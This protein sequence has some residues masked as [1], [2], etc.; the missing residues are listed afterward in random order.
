MM[1][2]VFQNVERQFDSAYE[3][4]DKRPLR[5]DTFSCAELCDYRLERKSYTVEGLL[6]QGLNILA[7]S[8]KIGKSWMV[9]H[10]CIQ[11]AKG[12]PFWGMK[13]QQGEVL[14]IA[15]E[16]SKQ[17]LQDRVLSLTDTPPDALHFSLDCA[18]LGD[19][20]D[21]ELHN[22]VSDYPQARLVVIDTFQKIRAQGKE[23]SYANDYAEVSRLKRTADE[24]GIC[25]LLVHHTRK[26][27]DSDY[28]NEISGTNGIAGSA[29]TLMVLKK[30]QR[31]SCNA[32][33]SC[34]G[35]DIEDRELT[36]HFD[37]ESC[38]WQV[39]EDSYKPVE[40]EMPREMYLLVSFM[41]TKEY[42]YGTTAE[43]AKKFCHASGLDILPNNLKRLMNI[44]R[45]DLEDEGVT[46][47]SVRRKD[48]VML[49]VNYCDPKKDEGSLPSADD[50]D[51]PKSSAEGSGEAVIYTG[52]DDLP[53]E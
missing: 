37:R 34:T 16:D 2:D 21:E 13:T 29:D 47:S 17:R 51:D 15:L 48:G 35:R 31:N 25:L 26:Q 5:L 27:A 11:V 12:Q 19:D 53:F 39:K 38:C 30:K 18:R 49:A 46:Y 52:E 3:A 10:L 23:M 4:Y 6:S 41:M 1:N 33:L 9:L 40:R 45:F 22:F 28:M 20:L 24:L 32:V 43:F 7:G 44:W 42:Y 14:Y 8:P 50:P 36:L